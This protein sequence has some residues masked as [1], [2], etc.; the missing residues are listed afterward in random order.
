MKHGSEL[1]LT[2]K[3]VIIIH[4]NLI[5]RVVT[6]HTH[7]WH[8]I[9]LPLAGL[10][11]VNCKDGTL[12]Q[13]RRGEMVIIPAD[14]AHAYEAS[15]SD[16]EQVILLFNPV[17]A[18]EPLATARVLLHSVLIAELC[19]LLLSGDHKS[20]HETITATLKIAV[21][22]SLDTAKINVAMNKIR[23]NI[24]DMRLRKAIGYI[25]R[26]FADDDVLEKSAKEGA[27]SFRTLSRLCKSDLGLSPGEVLRVVRIAH[28]KKLLTAGQ[29][30]VTEVAFDCGYNSMSQFIFNFKTATGT[31]PSQFRKK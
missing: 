3:E 26:N 24:R 31:L 27:A 23:S 18:K 20:E 14:L 10:V 8:E 19:I 2:L 4:Q 5:K 12:C 7:D 9:I 17:W 6:R 22:R 16:A 11:K 1:S 21:N 25:E 30:S 28:A 15:G 13:A 29:Y